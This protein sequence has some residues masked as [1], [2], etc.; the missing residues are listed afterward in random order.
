LPINWEKPS[1]RSYEMTQSHAYA[2]PS[3][4]FDGTTPERSVRDDQAATSSAV[5]AAHEAPLHDAHNSAAWARRGLLQRLH[6]K[7]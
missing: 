3:W 6:R 4:G 5:L 1:E 7:L 2:E